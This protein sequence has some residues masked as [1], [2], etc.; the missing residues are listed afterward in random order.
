MRG[1]KKMRFLPDT[2]VWVG[3]G[4]DPDLTKRCEQAL[5]AK[6]EFVIGPPALIEMVRGMVRHGK[7]TFS[8]DR[9]THVWMKDHKLDVL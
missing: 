9:K 8:E 3:V 4:R 5:A 1:H 2:N 6:H 7:E